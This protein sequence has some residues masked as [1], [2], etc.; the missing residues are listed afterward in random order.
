MK[1]FFYA[2]LCSLS[3]NMIRIRIKKRNNM[4]TR[5]LYYLFFS[6]RAFIPFLL[7]AESKV[8]ILGESYTPENEKYGINVDVLERLFRLIKNNN[9]KAVIFTGNMTLGLKK[10]TSSLPYDPLKPYLDGSELQDWPAPGY[11]YDSR[12]FQEELSEFL[13]LKNKTLG[14]SI[15]FYPIIGEHEAF[16]P[17][18][19]ERVLTTFQLKSLENQAPRDSSA[20]AYTFSIDNTL[21]ILFSTA[22]YSEVLKTTVSHQLPKGLLDWMEG[23]FNKEKGRYDFIFVVGNEPAYSTTGTSGHF[24]GLDL[25]GDSRDRFWRL[26]VNNG[27][28]AYF[29]AKEHLYDRTNRYGIRQIISGGA[30]APYYKRQFDKA[31][32][33][34]LILKLAPKGQFP[35]VQVFDSQGVLVDEFELSSSQFP[36]YQLRIS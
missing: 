3:M 33:H 21:F 24:D 8:A 10:D 20:L 11:K 17:D 28:T 13:A 9:P 31:F 19:V 15:P 2:S 35:K 25:H 34:Y 4:L 1:K 22:F 7:H 5:L 26:L 32:Y 18:A 6:F 12:Y 23:V 30:G 29:C 27:V 16:G 14:N 36:V